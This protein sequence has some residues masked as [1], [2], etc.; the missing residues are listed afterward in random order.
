MAMYLSPKK[1]PTYTIMLQGAG[2]AT[3]FFV[4]SVHKYKSSVYGSVKQ[5]CEK[6][7][8]HKDKPH[9]EDTKIP[10][11]PHSLT[12]SFNGINAASVHTRNLIFE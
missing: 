3:P 9:D 5:W 2:V 7:V 12:S 11:N 1:V 10:N 4:T 8:M 6:K